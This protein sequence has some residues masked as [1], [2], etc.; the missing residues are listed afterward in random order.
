MKVYNEYFPNIG[1]PFAVCIGKFD[2][3]HTGHR[4]VLHT[5][6][7]EARRHSAVSVAYSFEPRNNTPRL[8]TQD[9]KASLFASFGI[10]VLI[11]AELTHEFMA[12]T[13]EQFIQK[14]AACGELKAVAV[15][16]DFRFGRGAAGDVSLLKE[17][18]AKLGF[19]VHAIGQAEADGQPVSSTRIREC[20]KEGSVERAGL[21]L[22]RDYAL[23][24]E[25]IEGRHLAAKL[26]YRTANILPPQG[27]VIPAFGVYAAYV[28]APEGCWPAMVNIGVK[29]TIDG[30]ELLIESHLLGFSGD[31]Y[32]KRITVRLVKKIRD[33]IKFSN[34][35]Q[36]SAQLDK[37]SM[38]VKGIV[39]KSSL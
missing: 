2:G 35:K 3:L 23:S 12:Q 19:D 11:N 20:V 28:D 31:L 9:E 25:V 18:G 10:D 15:G 27:K 24:G 22:G 21:L 16:R 29:P 17:L 38:S 32:G 39:G 33:E 4:L 5:L 8:L 34:L 14:L 1:K 7:E 26:G 13:A 30:H 6:L 37:D 36:L